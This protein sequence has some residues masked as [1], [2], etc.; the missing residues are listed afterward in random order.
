MNE[1]EA[2]VE[3]TIGAITDIAQRVTRYAT[4][5]LCVA[6]V[7]SIGSLLLGIAALSGASG[8]RTLWIVRSSP[9]GASVRF[10][11]TCPRWRTKSGL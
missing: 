7:V 10:A 3:R 9:V 6:A 4:I 11:R 2:L 5:L 1:I 8:A